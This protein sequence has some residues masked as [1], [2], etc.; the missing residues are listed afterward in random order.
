MSALER[1]E[2]VERENQIDMRISIIGLMNQYKEKYG[3]DEWIETFEQ[4]YLQY[5]RHRKV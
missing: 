5:H 1:Y 3:C 2:E 4:D